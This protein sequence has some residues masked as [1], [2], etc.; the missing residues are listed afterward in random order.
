MEFLVQGMKIDLT[1]QCFF[2]YSLAD[3]V[4]AAA[5]TKA[6]S[7]KFASSFPAHWNKYG[8]M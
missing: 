4:A 8:D 5:D 2:C 1:S 3:F 7:V 6:A